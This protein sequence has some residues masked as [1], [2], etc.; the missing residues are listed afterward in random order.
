M[1]ASRTGVF[2]EP[3][4]TIEDL[5]RIVD[6]TFTEWNQRFVELKM[7]QSGRFY[8]DEFSRAQQALNGF[9]GLLQGILGRLSIAVTSVQWRRVEALMVADVKSIMAALNH[10]ITQMERL[11]G[12]L[13]ERHIYRMQY[14]SQQLS[15]FLWLLVFVFLALIMSTYLF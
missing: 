6:S 11:D 10:E 2:G 13:T 14:A 3:D 12:E 4:A 9:H 8:G 15:S 7:V 1:I 5:Q